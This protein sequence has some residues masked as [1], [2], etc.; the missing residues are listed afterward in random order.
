MSIKLTQ[1]EHLFSLKVSLTSTT[2]SVYVK[3]TLYKRKL[4]LLKKKLIECWWT[5]RTQTTSGSA[6]AFY[7]WYCHSL[8]YM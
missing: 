2:N 5:R 1:I 6:N 7:T 8:K 3:Q 4:V